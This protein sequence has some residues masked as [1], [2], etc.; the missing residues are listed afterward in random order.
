MVARFL[1]QSLILTIMPGWLLLAGCGFAPRSFKDL[2][3]GLRELHYQTEQ[4]YAPFECDFRRSL[5]DFGITLVAAPIATT[6]TVTVHYQLSTRD[7]N[8]G[9]STQARVYTI[10]YEAT[11]QV[12]NAQGKM[13][14]APATVSTS[15]NITLQPHEVFEITP[16]IATIKKELQR[17]LI[18]KLLNILV[19]AK[20]PS[21]SST[22][23]SGEN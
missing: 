2:P 8:S 10:T 18:N 4:R 12:S 14:L 7:T 9:S 13:L 22:D 17:E 5:T 1:K 20:L 23:H 16:Q 3:H 6:P 21:S 11:L 19:S 15:R